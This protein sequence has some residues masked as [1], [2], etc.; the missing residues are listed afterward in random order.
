[1][2]EK[3]VAQH[4]KD[5]LA[6]AEDRGN[7]GSWSWK[8]GQD[9]V[10]WSPGLYRLAGYLPMEVKPTLNSCRDLIHPDDLAVATDWRATQATDWL[11]DRVFRIVRKDGEIRRVRLH[12]HVLRDE[13][14]AVL[15][16]SGICIDVT[17]NAASVVREYPGLTHAQVRAAR[18]YLGWTA[19]EL[20]EKAGVSFS[21]VRRVEMPGRRAVRDENMDAIRD[22]FTRSGVRFV[23]H[24]DGAIGI[25][26]R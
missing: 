3:D 6:R 5:V 21:T 14:T 12:G 15:G 8:A 22:A 4:M 10:E 25:V 18:A 9:R 2:T 20:A 16:A 11:D 19:I 1:M 23:V 13:K 26:G 7:I 24:D 17:D